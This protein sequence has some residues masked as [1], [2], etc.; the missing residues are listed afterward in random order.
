MIPN[1]TYVAGDDLPAADFMLLL[2]RTV[3]HR[4]ASGSS[5]TGTMGRDGVHFGKSTGFANATVVTIDENHDWR[6]RVVT[7]FVYDLGGSGLLPGE[8][9][10]Y[11]DWA[12]IGAGS[13]AVRMGYLGTG[14]RSNTTTGAAVANGAPPLAASGT[15]VSYRLSLGSNFY[16]YADPTTGALKVY[17]ATGSTV[18]AWLDISG[19]ADL[20][21]H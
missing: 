17:N 7:A 11:T 14:A 20:G 18:Y 6:D 5:V 4:G 8:G 10:D 16:L 1:D 15:Y 3:G 19:T 21:V 2:E 13:P 12:S 9:T